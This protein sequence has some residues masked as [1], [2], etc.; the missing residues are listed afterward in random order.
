MTET[1]L[2]SALACEA[3]IIGVNARDLDTLAMDGARAAQVLAAIPPSVIRIDLSGIKSEA[4]IRAVARGPA[5]AVLMGEVLM[6]ETDPEP[7]LRA[8]LAA[9]ESG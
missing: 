3:R 4:D 8:L 9:C 6:R 2:V 7:R 5:D 1:E